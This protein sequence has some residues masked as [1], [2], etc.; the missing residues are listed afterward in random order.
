[1]IEVEAKVSV[2]DFTPVREALKKIYT[3]FI[4][5]SRDDDMYFNHPC[6]DFKNTDEA[7][8]IRN[9]SSEGYIVTYKGP[10]FQSST[11]SRVELNMK[12]ENIQEF[13]QLLKHLG[14]EFSAHVTKLR[15]TWK[16]RDLSISL[17]DVKGLG[18]FVEIE[19]KV[20]NEFEAEDAEAIIN[21]FLQ[22]LGLDGKP[23]IRESYLELII[24]NGAKS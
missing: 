10:R 3:S 13:L 6:R 1:M 21:G 19:V 18:K 24:Q 20:D 5:Y 22:K 16:I 9:S 12:V 4:G 15:E 14:F 2:D 11:K 23:T 17:D 7:L 8:R